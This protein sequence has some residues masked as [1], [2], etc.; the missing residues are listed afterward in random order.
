M[1]SNGP[2][3]RRKLI[4]KLPKLLRLPCAKQY[5]L[6]ILATNFHARALIPHHIVG[7]VAP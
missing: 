2:S 7:P 5:L 1:Q 4:K 3:F 6:P